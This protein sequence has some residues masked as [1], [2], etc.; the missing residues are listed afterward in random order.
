[1]TLTWVRVVIEGIMGGK[2]TEN[3]MSIVVI[4]DVTRRGLL[5]RGILEEEFLEGR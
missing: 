1:M 3:T 2:K 5:K 4:E